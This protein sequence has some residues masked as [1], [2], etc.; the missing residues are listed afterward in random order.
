LIFLNLLIQLI[1]YNTSAAASE[2]CIPWEVTNTTRLGFEL[3]SQAKRYSWTDSQR[4]DV[5]LEAREITR[6]QYERTNN[7]NAIFGAV[8]LALP[9]LSVITPDV[10]LWAHVSIFMG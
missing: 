3:Y 1:Q 5:Q 4:A 9:L 8:S 6:A 7:A 10:H 2:R